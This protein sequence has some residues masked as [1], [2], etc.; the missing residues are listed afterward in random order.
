MADMKFHTDKLPHNY[1][2][3]TE[4]KKILDKISESEK[5]LNNAVLYLSDRNIKIQSVEDV[6]A[7]SKEKVKAFIDEACEKFIASLGFCPDSLKL[8]T[9]TKYYDA[10]KE[11]C[12][13]IEKINAITEAYP[14][15]MEKRNNGFFFIDKEAQEYANQKATIH[16][17]K[18]VRDGYEL[19]KK[20]LDVIEEV[21]KWE[22]ENGLF[23][24]A[25]SGICL[26]GTNATFWEF[27]TDG[28]K[29]DLTPE[30]FLQAMRII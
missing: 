23:Q 30:K 12:P 11:L 26:G 5:S 19:H 9:R 20:M 16:L 3:H 15:S 13:Y 2:N 25:K 29:E 27:Y 24:V 8:D 14:I 1:I 10:Y 28:K 6:M 4:E 18:A 7:I 21:D 17:S 22:C